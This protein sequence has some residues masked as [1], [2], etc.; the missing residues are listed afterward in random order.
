MQKKLLSI[1]FFLMLPLFLSVGQAQASSIKWQE[2]SKDAFSQAKQEH[3]RVLI[4]GKVSWCHWCQQMEAYSFQDPLVVQIVNANYIPIRIDIEDSQ[5]L[6]SRYEIS[7]IPTV[8]IVDDENRIIKRYSGYTS[9]R[10]LANRLKEY[11][12]R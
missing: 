7:D 11:A 3:K 6:A 4:F 9:S 12:G 8:L 10:I 5:A 2:W 1:I